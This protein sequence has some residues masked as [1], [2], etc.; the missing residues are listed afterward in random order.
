M[1]VTDNVAGEFRRLLEH[2]QEPIRFPGGVWTQLVPRLARIAR[3][4][5]GGA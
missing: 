2:L 1:A 4:A 5:G 3:V